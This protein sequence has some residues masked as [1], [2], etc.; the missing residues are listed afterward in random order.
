VSLMVTKRAT[1]ALEPESFRA[2][3]VASWGGL[4]H[5]PHMRF[6][7]FPIQFS[8]AGF[9]LIEL[10]V[11]ISIIAIL[12]S[13]AFPA[14]NGAIDSARKA[15]A[16]N[17]VVQIAVAVSA[18]EMEYGKL[19]TNTG[20]T[21]NQDFIKALTGEVTNQNPRRIVFLEAQEWKK[22]KGGTNGVGFC[23]PWNSATP[24]SIALD[25]DYDN[26]IN[27]STNGTPAGSVELRKKVGVWNVTNNARFQVRSWD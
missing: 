7:K 20:G 24:Y 26:T 21:V 16:K 9:T 22:G 11:V 3:G 10:L 8:R 25:S 15:Q 6:F 5:C 14:V 18:Y 2:F 19:P 27:V 12:A 23:D 13:L 1:S 4:E 17:A